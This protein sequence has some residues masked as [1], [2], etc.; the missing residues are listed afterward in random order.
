MALDSMW[1]KDILEGKKEKNKE[2]SSGLSML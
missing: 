1:N 2:Q